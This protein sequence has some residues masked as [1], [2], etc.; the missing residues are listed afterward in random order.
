MTKRFNIH[1]FVQLFVITILL[2]NSYRKKAKQKE[3]DDGKEH[4]FWR[5]KCWVFIIRFWEAQNKVVE[6]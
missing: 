2:Q 1:L 3:N 6:Y 5:I 4:F